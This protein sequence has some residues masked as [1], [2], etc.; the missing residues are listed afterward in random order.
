[1][2][3]TDGRTLQPIK[4]TQI[5]IH[6]HY[7]NFKD[8]MQIRHAKPKLLIVTSLTLVLNVYGI[9]YWYNCYYVERASIIKE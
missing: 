9:S 5:P 8:T 1:M 7:F 6:E 2:T 3:T 4:T